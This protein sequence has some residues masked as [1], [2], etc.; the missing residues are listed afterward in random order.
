M[1]R[2]T[3][4]FVC[5]ALQG[6]ECERLAL[7]PMHH[8]DGDRFHT[9]FRVT[10]DLQGTGTGISASARARTIAALASPSSS[11][12]DFVRPGHVVPLRARPDGVLERPGHTEAAVDLARLAGLS[13][14]GALCEIVSEDQPGEMARGAE[15][16]R[17]AKEHD[18]V[19]ISVADL[20][21][22]RR[23]TE[24]QVRR[25][26][27]TSLPTEHGLFRA[28]GYASL[29]DASEHVA[30]V[31]DGSDDS[32]DTVP[33]HVHTECLTGDVL[34][35]TGCDCRQALDE[36]MARFSAERRGVVVYLR[37]AGTARTCD[38]NRDAPPGAAATAD[39]ILADLGVRA[40][41]GVI[42]PEPAHLD[43]WAAPTRRA[44]AQVVPS[45]ARVGHRRQVISPVAGWETSE[46]RPGLRSRVVIP[47][48]RTPGI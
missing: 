2:H 43:E 31:A 27:E 3:S 25:V 33:V 19:L 37:P 23:L 8:H 18:L 26:V 21:R 36:A 12:G 32:P 5:V 6:D 39:W 42:E 35:S 13:A 1:V 46:T 48:S 4:G 30:L 15:L 22:F 29:H 38:R 11:A 14:A 9:A 47:D 20:I 40:L 44:P 17:F 41:P 10:V 7:S 24:P 45:V 34:R 16:D 28:V